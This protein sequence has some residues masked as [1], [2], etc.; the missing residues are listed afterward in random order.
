MIIFFLSNVLRIIQPKNQVPRLKVCSVAR[1]HTDKHESEYR[2]QPFRVSGF[3]SLQPI[4]K[5]WSNY[6]HGAPDMK[7]IYFRDFS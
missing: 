2:G 3:F 7:F 5:D 1:G 6:P 4:I